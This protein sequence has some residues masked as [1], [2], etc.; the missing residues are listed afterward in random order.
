MKPLKI[1]H[2]ANFSD[3]KDGAVYYS[4][5]RKLTNGF[6]R[7]GHF[8]YPFSYRD[9]A[10]SSRTLFIKSSGKKA[11]LARL[12]NTLKN[13]NP[14]LLLLGHSELITSTDLRTIKACFPQLKIAMWWVDWI[15]NIRQNIDK[16]ATLDGF[17]ITTDPDELAPLV[18]DSALLS[19]CHYLPNLCDS[20][21]DIYD[22]S[23]NSEHQYDICFIGRYDSERQPLID[24]LKSQFGQYKLGIFGQQKSDLVFGN[25][26]YQ[27]LANSKIAINYSRSNTYKKYSSD[28]LI[29][30]IANGVL[31]LSARFPGLQELFPEAEV[32]AF[33][34]FDELST[35]LGRYLRDDYLRASAAAAARARAHTCYEATH[36]AHNMLE[37]L[38]QR[39]TD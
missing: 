19:R 13:L 32:P 38:F 3:L 11:M 14:E 8:V 16:L 31:T 37:T 29:Q 30:P 15:P 17:F 12:H 9:I 33:S 23:R 24:F 6:I 21:I 7:N 27:V 34:N 1:L 36:I 5:D 22:S 10:K 35:L 26:F 20:S 18:N 28:R 2:C 4:I 39:S 25:D